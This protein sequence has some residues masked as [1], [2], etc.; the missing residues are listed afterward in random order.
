MKK[1]SKSEIVI[2]EFLEIYGDKY[3]YSLVEYKG[4]HEH[5]NIK[6]YKH[7]NFS[8]TP[9]K[10]RRGSE[11]KQCNREEKILGQIK[12]TLE[13]F[14]EIHGDKYDYSLMNYVSVHKKVK[15]ICKEHGIFEQSPGHHYN[16]RGCPECA[17]IQISEKNTKS[18]DKIIKDFK[19]VHGNK[20]D[21]SL[22]IY[23]HIRDKVKIICEHHGLFLQEPFSHKNGGGCPECKR[24]NSTYGK[25]K[26]NRPGILYYFKYKGAWKL[27]ITE[28]NLIKRYSKTMYSEM[29]EIQV[30]KFND[31][32]NAW[33]VEQMLIRMNKHK[34]YKGEKILRS[35]NSELFCEDIFSSI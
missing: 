27:G 7:G 20:Y 25:P 32:R 10:H 29:S 5:I 18:N 13:K 30:W 23:K 12:I 22:V 14:D 24:E 34:K 35:G 17:V 19:K 33:K 21:Y 3:D 16:G 1:L 15:I 2:K 28:F 26:F 6:C 11:C 4:T 8:V 31:V 9:N